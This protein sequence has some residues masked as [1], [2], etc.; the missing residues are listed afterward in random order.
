[1][2]E[3]Q[4]TYLIINLLTFIF[5]II[6]SFESKIKFVKNWKFVFPAIF[7]TGTFFIIWDV[8]KTKY[9]VWSFNEEYL[10][11]MYLIN[12][13][14][15]EWMFFLTVPFACVFVYEVVNFYIKNDIFGKI[16]NKLSIA[17][18]IIL[19]ILAIVN[20]DKSYT[21]IVFSFG[22][23]FA[24]IHGIFFKYQWLGKFYL[25][26]LASLLPFFI[27]NGFLTALPVVIYNNS[28]NLG[29]RIYTIPIEDTIYSFLLLLMNLTFYEYFKKKWKK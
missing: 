24:L 17:L 8:F 16:A 25:A 2:I 10:L 12:L 14:L 19:L 13:P 20:Y 11:G 26:Y 1:M 21:S 6:Q 27:V 23:I 7:L 18:G 29:I 4:F 9:G 15:E 3:K 22:G 5:P 28:E